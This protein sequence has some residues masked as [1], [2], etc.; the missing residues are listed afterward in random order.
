[1]PSREAWTYAKSGVNTAKVRKAQKSIAELALLTFNL[2][3][4][5]VGEVLTDVGHYAGLISIGEGKALALH[6][7]GVGTKVLVA[8][9]MDNYETIGIDAV[10]MCVNDLICVG[11]EPLALIDYLVV[12]EPNE[13]TIAKIVKGLVKG[14]EEAEVALVGGETA[15]MPDVIKG[16]VKGQGFDLAALGV[17]VVDTSKLVTGGRLKPGDVVIGLESSG[18]HSNGLTLAR[19]VLLSEGRSVNDTLPGFERTIGEE[20]LKPTRIYV[21]PV[22]QAL[23]EV[24]V[25]ALAHITG[26]AF[27]KLKR[28]EPYA[29]V[30]FELDQMPEPSP[31]FKAVQSLGRVSDREMYKTFNMGVG[32]CVIT[33]RS[34]ADRAISIFEKHRVKA[35]VIGRVVDQLG[36]RVKL[37]SG[38]ISY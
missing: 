13:Q 3:K 11:A 15:V 21:K 7:D 28:F 33:T 4:N 17:G 27:T 5:R 25:H 8:Q 12:E 32:F 9:L 20:L 22:L 34:D 1:M 29:K 19:K 26:G 38:V 30:G 18:I 6:V 24:E 36:V 10:A 37:P 16:A 31:I 14:C 2:R 35:W 23:S